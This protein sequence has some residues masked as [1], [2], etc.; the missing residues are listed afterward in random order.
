M[1][2]QSAYQASPMSQQVK[3][4]PAVQEMQVRFPGQEG[5]LEEEMET[6][7]SILA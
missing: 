6:C 1:S 5:L 2:L 7:I 4:A 3:N